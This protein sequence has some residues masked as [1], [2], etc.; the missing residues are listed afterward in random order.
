MKIAVY[1]VTQIHVIKHN[2]TQIHVIKYFPG[3]TQGVKEMI[4]EDVKWAKITIL[5]CKTLTISPIVVM[6]LKKII[7]NKDLL[8]LVFSSKASRV[9]AAWVDSI[10]FYLAC[11]SSQQQPGLHSG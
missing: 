3:R 9:P 11:E 1:N 5:M 10:C 2:V 8:S 7:D 6:E 4:M